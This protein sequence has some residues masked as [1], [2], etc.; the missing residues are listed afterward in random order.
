MLYHVV[1]YTH[2]P[3]LLKAT[4]PEFPFKVHIREFMDGRN[5]SSREKEDATWHLDWL[6]FDQLEGQLRFLL[7]RSSSSRVAAQH[8]VWTVHVIVK[9]EQNTVW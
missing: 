6:L 7:S 9:Q 1:Q 8:D 5:D 4:S 2:P 3:S